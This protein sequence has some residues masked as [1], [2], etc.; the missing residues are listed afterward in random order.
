MVED[1]KIFRSLLPA[2]DGQTV[3]AFSVRRET[4]GEEGRQTSEEEEGK[5]FENI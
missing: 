2:G 3:T 4:C 1:V 5:L